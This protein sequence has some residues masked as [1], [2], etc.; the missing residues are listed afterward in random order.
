MLLLGL[1]A[2]IMMQLSELWCVSLVWVEGFPKLFERWNDHFSRYQR[3]HESQ[4]CKKGLEGWIWLSPVQ[5]WPRRDL[6]RLM[7][8]AGS[9][10]V[11]AERH[12]M[13]GWGGVLRAGGGGGGTATFLEICS[14]IHT[15]YFI[16]LSVMSMGNNKLRLRWNSSYAHCLVGIRDVASI[17]VRGRVW[18]GGGCC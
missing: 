4:E 8:L 3:V 17:K 10:P 6:R 7:S 12:Y 9:R 14:C 1:F 5:C 16:L 2:H 11:Q 13:L 18:P 15:Q